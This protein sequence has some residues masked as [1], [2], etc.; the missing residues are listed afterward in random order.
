MQPFKTSDS[1]IF[2]QMESKKGKEGIQLHFIESRM[3]I[4]G[5]FCKSLF[6]SSSPF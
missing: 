2:E 3:F 1:I 5:D 6:A 4:L